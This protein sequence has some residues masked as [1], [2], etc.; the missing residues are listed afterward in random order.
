VPPAA[1]LILERPGQ[2]LA[3]VAVLHCVEQFIGHDFECVLESGDALSYDLR[4]F[5]SAFETSYVFQFAIRRGQAEMYVHPEELKAYG[6]S[7]DSFVIT[8][9]KSE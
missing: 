3:G 4:S 8:K 9:I 5:C 1:A 6:V 2:A 7:V